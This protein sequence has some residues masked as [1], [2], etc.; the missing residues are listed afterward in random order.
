[1]RQ[2][3]LSNKPL[4]GIPRRLRALERWASSFRDKFYPRSEHMERYT[5]WKIP[6]HA[7]LV[8][9]SQARADQSCS[10]VAHASAFHRARA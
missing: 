4:R 10:C 8:Q 7:A 1:M 5:H 2:I 9:G 6:V 3:A